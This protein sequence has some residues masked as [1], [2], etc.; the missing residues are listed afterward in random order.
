MKRICFVALLSV[1]LITVILPAVYAE[2]P[3]KLTKQDIE[4]LTQQRH[5]EQADV[6]VI[7]KL[8]QKGRNDLYMRIAA[9]NCQLLE[10]FKATREYLGK[11]TPA[12]QKAPI[13]PKGYNTDYLTKEE[14]DYINSINNRM[15][16]DFYKNSK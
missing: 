7:S 6:D 13:A 14:Y 12:Q 8:N 1:M 4:F 10:P 16:E 11:Y 9:R 15:L 5:V 2:E 3:A